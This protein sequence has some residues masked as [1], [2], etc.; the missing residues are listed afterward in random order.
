MEKIDVRKY[1]KYEMMFHRIGILDDSDDNM[2]WMQEDYVKGTFKEMTEDL[3]PIDFFVEFL[4]LCKIDSPN[5]SSL[6]ENIG[7]F[8]KKTSSSTGYISIQIF[9]KNIDNVLITPKNERLD[10]T[11]KATIFFHDFVLSQKEINAILHKIAFISVLDSD[12]LF[13]TTTYNNNSLTIELLDFNAFE[14]SF[15]GFKIDFLD[16]DS[17]I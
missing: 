10:N 5:F 16:N 7:V 9:N 3:S 6:I 15:K 13:K 1:Q 2:S 8:E 17:K 12:F 4:E 14:Q 11:K